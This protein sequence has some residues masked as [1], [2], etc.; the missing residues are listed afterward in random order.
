MIC[1]D[2]GRRYTRNSNSVSIK[3]RTPDINSLEGSNSQVAARSKGESLFDC[4]GVR[5]GEV[6]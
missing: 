4:E 6:G 3:C 2:N 5:V 1:L